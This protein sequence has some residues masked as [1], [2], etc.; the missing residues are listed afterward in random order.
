MTS[1]HLKLDLRNKKISFNT[2][3]LGID[4]G[5]LRLQQQCLV[6]DVHPAGGSVISVQKRA[7][8]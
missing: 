1:E 6:R 8:Q 5:Y 2:S 7:C 3:D 4:Y